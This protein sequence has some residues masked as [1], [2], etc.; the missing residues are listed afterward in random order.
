MPVPL[1][2]VTAQP[3]VSVVTP[4]YNGERYLGECIESVLAQSYHHWEYIIV[5]NCSTDRTVAIAEQYASKDSRIGLRHNPAFVNVLQNHNIAFHH[6]SPAS[7][8]CKIVHAD[9]W[10]F[11]DCLAAM[12]K[13]AEAH[14]SV[15]LVGSYCLY[16]DRVK[17]DGLPYPSTVVSGRALGRLSLLGEVYVF[18]SPTSLLIRSELIRN[19]DP[20]YNEAHLHADDEA[21]Y[22]VLQ[23]T[24]FGFVHQVLTFIRKHEESLT[25]SVAQRFNTLML[26]ELDLLVRYGPVYLSPEEYTSRVHHQMKD[27]Y[28]FLA[29]N[30][31][32]VRDRQQFWSYH[33]SG[34]KDLGYP[35]SKSKLM[36]EML[37]EA[38]DRVLNPKRTISNVLGG[39][40]SWTRG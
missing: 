6:M 28:R 9:D 12:V 16:G 17:S 3:L 5:N 11:P 2:D 29:Q 34:L 15:G 36:K 4:V 33:Q 40:R 31:F 26:A 18:W 7:R 23:H 22:E 37:L 39:I 27:Y 24:D 8:Y 25:A 13:T 14:P 19:H 38:L 35:L 10:L 32:R 30:S 21:S 1:C 20:F